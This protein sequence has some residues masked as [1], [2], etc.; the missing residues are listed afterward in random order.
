MLILL[1]DKQKDNLSKWSYSVDD[2]SI[3]T[4]ILTPF[5]NNV[6]KMV[7]DYVAPNVLS[8]AGLLLTVYSYYI[9]CLY[10]QAYPR[11]VS[12][13]C[14]FLLFGYQTLDAIDGKHARRIG[15]DSPL[16]E[17]FDHACDS[18]GTIF[19][20]MTVA[21]TLGI[22][23]PTI[24]FYTTQS[25][26]MLFL[27]EHL[28]A[29]RTH[30][31]TFFRY[32]GPGEILLGCI[33]I[34]IWKFI[35]GWSLIPQVI[36]HSWLSSVIFFGLYWSIYIYSLAYTTLGPDIVMLK[37][38]VYK[39]FNESYGTN[40]GILLCLAMR[41]IN[42]LLLW[43]GLISSWSVEDV[44][45][46]GLILS[47]VISDLIVAK[48]AQRE[49]HPI[50]V[51]TSMLSI[52]N[53]NLMIY[54]L[55]SVYFISIF[56]EICESMGLPL[57]TPT[58]NVYASNV[59]DLIHLNHIEYFDQVTRL[60]NRLLIGVHDNAEIKRYNI[61]TTLT[62]EERAITASYCR[63]VSKV[64][65][66]APFILTKEFIKKYNIHKVVATI[67]YDDPY[68]EYYRVPREMGILHIIDRRPRV[69][70]TEITNSTAK[71]SD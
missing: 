48:M 43:Y 41:Y 46:H 8:L 14:A 49:L 26:L 64:I 3:T 40:V 55:V 16:G 38:P 17:L 34:L 52:F 45:A 37:I 71:S 4:K 44:I 19:V 70:Q 36:L 12:L 51:I 20:T 24:L 47:V 56:Y 32:T 63:G 5:W 50:V 23:S 33:A 7:P 21:T 59:W 29:Y 11:F 66:S 42:G 25:C 60:G 2:S 15:N 28:K 58:V 67:E 69:L 6:A 18:V 35:T 61:C 39:Q 10:S 9:T 62:M 53:H 13:I 27:L 30:K 57:L 65:R 22:T 1:T 68:D 31:V 54:I